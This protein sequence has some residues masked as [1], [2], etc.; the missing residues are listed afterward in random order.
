MT[1]R[2]DDTL[3]KAATG[4]EGGLVANGSTCGVVTGGALGLALLHEGNLERGGHAAEIA[5]IARIREYIEW[6]EKEFATTKCSERMGVD[7]YRPG[8][9]IRYLLP[10]DKVGRCFLQIRRAA[11][12]LDSLSRRALPDEEEFPDIETERI[13][14]CAT[15]V[16]EGIGRKTGVS[17]PLLERLSFIFDGG[18]ALTGGI[19]GAL[20]GSIMAINLI[21]GMNTRRMN[22]TDIIRDFLIGHINLLLEKPRS[23]PEP[24]GVGREI[25]RRFRE[26]A[27]SINCL[28][29]TKRRFE[30][31]KDF[32]EY[33]DSSDRCRELI[34]FS[35]EGTSKV[36][37]GLIG[38]TA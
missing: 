3:L 17:D 33:R 35:I 16:L 34:E 36:I 32:S 29:I 28:D 10:G 20:A 21:L 14:H 9:Q 26:K 12:K 4:F 23:M 13:P 15:P 7:F 22:Y 8:G 27:G 31:G 1:G 2:K 37:E 5:V 25:V 11:G 18:I 24:F 30:N 38:R 6:F 19:C